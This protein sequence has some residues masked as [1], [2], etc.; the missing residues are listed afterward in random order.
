[1]R[2]LHV[3]RVKEASYDL[4]TDM[5]IEADDKAFMLKLA[6]TVRAAIDDKHFNSSFK[7]AVER[8]RDASGALITANDIVPRVVEMTAKSYGL[9]QNEQDGVLF[10]L[11]SGGD[12]SLYGL[13]SAVT[14]ASQDIVSYDRATELERIGWQIAT[15][16]RHVWQGM[17]DA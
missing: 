10:H 4:Y 15:M 7:T 9:T 13:S 17:N 8:L 3:G 5:T 2:K 14:K 12:L 1:M 6:D 11:L 16:P